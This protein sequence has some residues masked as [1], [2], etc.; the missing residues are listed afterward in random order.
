MGNNMLMQSVKAFNF[1]ATVHGFQTQFCDFTQKFY[2]NERHENK[3][4]NASDSYLDQSTLSF[5]EVTE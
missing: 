5:G 2:I 3:R 4:L 1:Q